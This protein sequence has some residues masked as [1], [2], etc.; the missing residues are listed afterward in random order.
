VKA[1]RASLGA[2]PHPL[3]AEQLKALAE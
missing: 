1:V 3:N 2:R